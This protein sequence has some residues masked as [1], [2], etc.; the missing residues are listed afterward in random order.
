MLLVVGEL[1]RMVSL[2]VLRSMMHIVA[3]QQQFRA[4]VLLP[5]CCR[6]SGAGVFQHRFPPCILCTVKPGM[7]VQV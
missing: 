3:L 2:Q 6:A 1:R 4:A 7:E 5:G